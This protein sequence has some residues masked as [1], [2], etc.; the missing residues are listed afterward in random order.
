MT[1]YD[2]GQALAAL[3][4]LPDQRRILV[5]TGESPSRPGC[6]APCKAWHQRVIDGLR[7]DLAGDELDM[8]WITHQHSDHHGGLP[9]IAKDVKILHYVDNGEA[10]DKAG[11]KRARKAAT[12]SGAAL[13]EVGPGKTTI[14]IDGAGDVTL[15]AIVPT[16]WPVDCEKNPNDCSIG[17]L[18]DYCDSEILFTGDAEEHAEEAWEVGDVDLLQAGHHGSDTSS[19]QPFIDKIKPSYSVVSTARRGEGTNRTYCH[20]RKSTID[21]LAAAS[22]STGG[23]T[24]AAFDAA[25]SCKKGTNANWVDTPTGDNVW[26]TAR[27]GTVV[28]QT[29]GDG[30][31]ARVD[32]G[33][34]YLSA[35]AIREAIVAESIASYPGKCPCPNDTMSNGRRCGGNSAHSR[36]AGD[37]P[38]CY[39]EDVSDESVEAYRTK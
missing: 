13:A 32:T 21:R 20:P 16:Q 5:D 29:T 22:G 9:R 34:R 33:A 14:P 24:V 18:V 27:D 15:T 37:A 25:V 30:N 39:P 7:V 19:S 31:F 36:G 26:V 8:V 6:G 11:V 10:P 23:P 17:L 3:V 35:A 12:D 2:A 28:L 1:F 38:L 4:T